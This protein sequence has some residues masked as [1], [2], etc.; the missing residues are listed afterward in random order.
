MVR[1]I[2]VKIPVDIF[3][4]RPDAAD[5]AILAGIENGEIFYER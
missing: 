5:A 2:A 4:V 1:N 3:S